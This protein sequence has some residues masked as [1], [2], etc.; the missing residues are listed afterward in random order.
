MTIALVPLIYDELLDYF[1]RRATPEEILAF[2]A[3]PQAEERA[4]YLL[5]RNNAGTLTPEERLELD[6][7]LYF[8]GKISILKAKAA[9]E[10]KQQR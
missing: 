5:D 3:S 10:L 7:M 6:Q 1:A 9:L 4:E 2:K 8:D